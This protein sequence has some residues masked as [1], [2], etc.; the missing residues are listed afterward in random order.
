MDRHLFPNQFISSLQHVTRVERVICSID[1]Y[2]IRRLD[3]YGLCGQH[4][5]IRRS[6]MTTWKKSLFIVLISTQ[7][8]DADKFM[9]IFMYVCMYYIDCSE[10][11]KNIRVFFVGAATQTMCA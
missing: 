9:D 1:L 10:F 4:K 11:S 8:L 6:D 7:L 3:Y 2:K 5:E